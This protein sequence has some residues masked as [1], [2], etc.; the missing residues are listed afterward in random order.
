MPVVARKTYSLMT[1][2]CLSLVMAFTHTSWAKPGSRLSNDEKMNAPDT[3][4]LSTTQVQ[5]GQE[6]AA[7]AC[8][9]CHGV[10][11][12]GALGP[13]LRG[14]TFFG[15]WSGKPVAQLYDLVV[16]EMPPN[17]SG[18]LQDKEYLDI[19]SFIL[20]KNGFP[21]SE[22][23]PE[24][25]DRE[26]LEKILFGGRAPE[27]MPPVFD[28]RKIDQAYLNNPPQETWPSKSRTPNA[29]RYSPLDQINRANVD[30]LEVAWVL[31][32]GVGGAVEWTPVVANDVMFV[33]A[34]MT[35]IIAANAATGDLLWTYEYEPLPEA[36]RPDPNGGW[37]PISR[38]LVLYGNMVITQWF[39][40]RI[41]A[42]DA[43]TGQEV[44]E[45][46]TNG[47][48]YTSPG[49]VADGVL[50]SGSRDRKDDRGFIT[51]IDPNTGEILWR[52]YTIP[53]PGEP[54]YETWEIK[55]TAESGHGS[56]W[57]TPS[58]DPEL[59]LVYVTTSSA[60]PYTHQT[61]PGDNLYTNSIL[62][63]DPQTGDIQWYHQF[64]PN[65]SWD[66]DSTMEALLIDI[67]FQDAPRKALVHT[68][69][70]GFTNLLD[71][72]DGEWLGSMFTTYQNIFP[73]VNEKGRPTLNM[74]VVPRP[75]K[76]VIAC[77]STRGGTDWPARAY[78]PDT[79]LYYLSGNNICMDVEGIPFAPGDPPRNIDDTFVLAPNYNHIGELFAINPVTMS[80]VW[81]LKYDIPTSAIPLPTA[82][83]LVFAGDMDR[84]F[85]AYRDDTGEL[86]WQQRLNAPVEGHPISYEVEGVQYVAVPTGC[87]SA[88]GGG[89]AQA[90]A[91]EILGLHGT[92]QVWVFRL[93]KTGS[94]STRE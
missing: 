50:V 28:W 27:E 3:A 49:I 29:W 59:N 26:N 92:G 37:I 47:G 10:T 23:A 8:S 18:T 41:V 36:E 25:Q 62:A 77:P 64:I 48:G 34:N 30:R 94:P 60:D 20:S 91:P 1:G 54:G 56:V 74:D 72:E 90:L 11:L 79:G 46:F 76:R 63:L 75:G 6:A 57:G 83:G 16:T 81:S 13:A 9:V 66:Q 73:D 67:I 39:D 65:D 86:L 58:Y 53:G 52:T 42:L 12:N 31:E 71:R 2:I 40:S 38:G 43:Q 35:R 19:V 14:N 22:T 4:T 80:V 55:G 24:L 78:S 93:G 84:F 15:N 82:G 51:G 69:K 17:A 33:Q 32:S 44:W 68:G 70:S 5:R 85:R 21:S 89:I 61:R 87:C 7:Q 45:A 88:V